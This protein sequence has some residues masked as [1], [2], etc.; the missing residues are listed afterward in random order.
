MVRLHT[1]NSATYY[2][3]TDNCNP[4]KHLHSWVIGN[5]FPGSHV[6]EEEREPG[7]HC[8][9]MRQVPLVT[10]SATL[11][12]RSILFTCWKAALPGYT[13]SETHMSCFESIPEL[14][15]FGTFI[16]FYCG[17]TAVI[18]MVSTLG[19]T[20]LSHVSMICND[21]KSYYGDSMWC[22]FPVWLSVG[23]H[24]NTIF[25]GFIYPHYVYIGK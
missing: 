10:C 15:K 5:H 21:H 4:S 12:L 2:Q 3:T 23:L 13:P 24:P 17:H 6:G 18:L 25:G 14:P 20:Y 16:I 7:I 11:K 8:S 9:Y 19:F 22:N 1:Y